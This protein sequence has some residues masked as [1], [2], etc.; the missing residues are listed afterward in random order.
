MPSLTV[1]T[2]YI[3][4]LK[5]LNCYDEW[6]TNVKVQYGCDFY[7]PGDWIDWKSFINWSFQWL[8]TPE[9]SDFWME[10]FES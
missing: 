3:E 7:R 2:I 9:G 4:K 5:G 8:I 10:K 6:L 1:K